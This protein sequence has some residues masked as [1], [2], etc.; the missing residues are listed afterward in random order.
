LDQNHINYIQHCRTVIRP[1]EVDFYMP[2]HNLCIECNGSFWHST[3]KHTKNYHY[4]KYLKVL[5]TK[6]TLLSFW[7]DDILNK[8]DIVENLILLHCKERNNSKDL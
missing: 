7:E 2:E 5:E 4:K 6:N 8:P 3:I 1:L